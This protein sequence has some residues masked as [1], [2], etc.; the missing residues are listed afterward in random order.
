M[1]APRTVCAHTISPRTPGQI[2]HTYT[3][4]Y[5]YGRTALLSPNPT[6][7]SSIRHLLYLKAFSVISPLSCSLKSFLGGLPP[8]GNQ[9]PH[10]S[11]EEEPSLVRWKVPPN[12]NRS[13]LAP[14][15]TP[16][17]LPSRRAEQ[18][19]PIGGT[20]KP[21]VTLTSGRRTESL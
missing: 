19:G 11:L 18:R 20:E 7:T 5:R 14:P 4:C 21:C 2:D 15:E 3:N 16:D 6:E 12:I 13:F 8:C 17:K 1:R 10:P 9:S